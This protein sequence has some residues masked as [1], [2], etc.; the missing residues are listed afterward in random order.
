MRGKEPQEVHNSAMQPA[1]LSPRNLPGLLSRSSFRFVSKELLFPCLSFLMYK[2]RVLSKI[3]EPLALLVLLN[4]SLFDQ[5]LL[6]PS[7]DSQDLH[8]E[9]R[10]RQGSPLL[11]THLLS[12]I[13]L[14]S[15]PG[16]SAGHP[17]PFKTWPLWLSLLSLPAVTCIQAILDHVKLWKLAT[18]PRA[19]QRLFYPTWNISRATAPS[20]GPIHSAFRPQLESHIFLRILL[21]SP[22]VPPSSPPPPEPGRGSSPRCSGI[23]CCHS[24]S[25]RIMIPC[26]LLSLPH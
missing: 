6:C 24:P 21:T 14:K 25:Y 10:L 26:L 5:P 4:L 16:S 2:A 19:W 17:W 11:K 3:S 7:H 22:P 18:A 9:T 20:T 8:P 13:V 12:P 23:C 15:S 1:H